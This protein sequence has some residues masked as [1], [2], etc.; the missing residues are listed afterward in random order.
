[1]NLGILKRLILGQRQ[2]NFN[3]RLTSC[4]PKKSGSTQRM[5]GTRQ[6]GTEATLKQFPLA[7]SGKSE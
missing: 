3:M 2:R 4:V 7:K 6:K 1:M 5:L